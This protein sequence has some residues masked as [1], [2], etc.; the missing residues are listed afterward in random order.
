MNAVFALAIRALISL[1]P[2][3]DAAQV[4][5]VIYLLQSFVFCHRYLQRVISF[6]YSHNFRFLSLV[7]C[8]TSFQLR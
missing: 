4:F 7:P 6:R 5:E 2:G 8:H 1:S 3:Y